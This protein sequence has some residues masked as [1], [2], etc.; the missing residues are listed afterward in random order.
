[1]LIL[2]LSPIFKA[3]GIEKPYAFLVKSGLT[4]HAAVKILNNQFRVYRL[5]HIEHLCNVLVCEP[6]DLLK[7]IPEKG[8]EYA[9]D[10]PLFKLKQDEAEINLQE[11]FANMSYKKLKEISKTFLEENNIAVDKENE[12]K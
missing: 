9:H 2:N 6:N 11:T 10:H 12:K 1:M 7:W 5:D 4:P 3:R 8:K